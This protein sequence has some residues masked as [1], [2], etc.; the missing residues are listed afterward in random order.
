MIL[1]TVLWGVSFLLAKLALQEISTS[2]FLF[3]RYAV[4]AVSLLPFFLFQPKSLNRKLIK[5]GIYLSLLQAA[6]MFAQTI[7]LETISA[8]LSSFV[9]GFYIVFVLLIRFIITKKL[10]TAVDIITSLLCLA[11][12]GLL[13]NSFGH[14]DPV[15]IGYTFIC[16]LFIAIHIYLLDQY[17][18][19]DTAFTLT[20]L[21][22]V[23]IM[24][25]FGC[26]LLCNHDLFQF[27]RKLL[28]W[29][30]ILV[31]G[32]GCSSVA[33]WLAAKAQT[34]LG[35][36]KTS[37]ILMLEPVFATLFAYLGLG[38]TLYPMS[39]VGIGMILIAIGIINWRLAQGQSKTS[40]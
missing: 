39:F 4:A 25:I 5:P 31:A 34:K 16:A 36:F 33:Y 17:L 3:F 6:L 23:G 37:I 13:T 22:M 20:F 26:V 18:N 12:L 19:E 27:P 21:Q 35:A 28:T 29:G 10:P 40:H 7:G 30:S 14:P 2:S 38:E 32:I 24:I 1:A 9:S 11:G 15:G 8:S